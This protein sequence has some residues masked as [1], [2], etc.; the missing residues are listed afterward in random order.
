MSYQSKQDKWGTA[1]NVK[2]GSWVRVLRRAKDME[3]GWDNDWVEGDMCRAVGRKCQ[4]NYLGE[5]GE[6]IE[7]SGD[8]NDYS[9]PYFVLEV[10]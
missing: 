3:R 10:L 1:N 9:F 6:G 7:L 2:V 8:A 4:V 5:D